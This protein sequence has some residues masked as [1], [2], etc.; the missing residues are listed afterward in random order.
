MSRSKWKGPHVK[1]ES[2]SWV[3][4]N[5]NH[6]ISGGRNSEIIPEFVGQVFQIYNGNIFNSIIITEDMVGH[7]FGEFSLTRKKFS[8]KK[9]SKSMLQK[10]KGRKVQK[11]KST[12]KKKIKTIKK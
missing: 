10:G 1:T 8:F 4:K 2:T 3:K 9:K 5:Y 12:H 6:L 11:K 7:K